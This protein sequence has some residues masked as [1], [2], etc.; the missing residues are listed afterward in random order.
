MLI[1]NFL[2]AIY[3][4]VILSFI[5]KFFDI[6]TLGKYTF[7]IALVTPLYLFTNLQV[8]TLIITDIENKYKINDYYSFRILSNI[9]LLILLI[10]LVFFFSIGDKWIIL[11]FAII[12]IVESNAEIINAYYQKIENMQNVAIS[13][14]LKS[15]LGII[16]F[17]LG[18]QIFNDIHMALCM[19]FISSLSVYFFYDKRK[20]Q[21]ENFKLKLNYKKSNYI[22]Y[23]NI[24]VYGLPLGL[25]MLLVSLNGNIS[26]F[27]IENKLGTEKQ[28]IYSALS[29]II[30]LGTFVSNAI[31]QAFVPRLSNYFLKNKL[32]LFLKIHLSF[33]FFNIIIGTLGVFIAFFFGE[34]VL[35][36]F[37]NREISKYSDLL[38]LVMIIGLLNY[39][40]TALGYTQTAMKEFKIQP[41]IGII[42]LL[43]QIG[44]IYLLIDDYGLYGVVYATI[45]SYVLQIIITY[46]NII[47]KFKQKIKVN[48]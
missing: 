28:G 47:Y 16:C 46:G 29:Y 42:N 30:I 20:F 35:L 15:V 17:F 44:L 45:L 11:L 19:N 33:V 5:A 23:K 22:V 4:W 34:K 12:K 1:S 24:F 38:T 25:V 26:K 41:Y 8:R 39:F 18:V 6:E 27:I 13:V 3:N 43:F 40:L 2:Y 31:G 9:F 48:E 36:L 32:K 10:I 7:A 21:K 14:G 37:F